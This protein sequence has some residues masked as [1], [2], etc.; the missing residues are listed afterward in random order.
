MESAQRFVEVAHPSL[1]AAGG[2]VKPT[3]ADFTQRTSV[4]SNE[5]AHK[6]LSAALEYAR[7]GLALLPI[8]PGSKLPAMKLLPLVNGRPSWSQ[9]ALNPASESEISNWFLESPDIDIAAICG[10]PSGNLVVVDVDH[11][12]AVGGLHLP[13]SPRATTQRGY[14]AFFRSSRPVQNKS[15]AAGEILACKKY[16]VLPL[17]GDG[18]RI[19]CEH[20]AFNEIEI[21]EPPEWV[22]GPAEKSNTLRK[23]YS[24]ASTVRTTRKPVT[25]PPL[26]RKAHSADTDSQITAHLQ[27]L[28]KQQ[29]VVDKLCQCLGIPTRRLRKGFRC[30]LPGHDERSPSASLIRSRKTDLIRYRDWHVVDGTEWYSLAEVYAA[31]RTNRVQELSA[32]EALAWLVRLYIDAGVIEPA[33]VSLRPLP[34]NAKTTERKV[35]KGFRDLLAVKYLYRPGEP[36]MFTRGFASRWSGVGERQA[37]A[38]I[39]SLVK[40]GILKVDK[41]SRTWTY[42]PN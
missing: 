4:I 6:R 37:A 18:H 25:I 24:S 38:A 29:D 11:P 14:H 40:R 7:Y 34:K 35:W 13:I 19:W 21:C 41:S 33:R 22:Y 10:P 5:L 9:L 16:V 2:L 8:E 30:I 42:S 27:A 12:G 26:R 31:I 20:L 3:A 17:P 23:R 28:C 1:I 36:T 39:S 15:F 32:G